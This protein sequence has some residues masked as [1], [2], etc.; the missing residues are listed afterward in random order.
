MNKLQ[1]QVITPERTVF[2]DQVD[3]VILPTTSGEIGVLPNHV[4]M[5]TIIK[6]GE[7]R[8]KKGSETIYLATYGGCIEIYPGG[9]R[10]LADAAERAEEI[11]ELKAIEAKERAEHLMKEAK[12]DVAFADAAAYLERNLIQIKVANRK[13]HHHKG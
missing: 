1:L 12:D 5:V 9:I 13:K 4:P 10:V 3:E 11:D 8:I 2:D 6:P 7:V